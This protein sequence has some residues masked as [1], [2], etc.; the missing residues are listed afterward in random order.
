MSALH[1][2]VNLVS[3]IIFETA[4][5]CVQGGMVFSSS[6]FDCSGAS[7]DQESTPATTMPK[8]M[9]LRPLAIM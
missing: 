2:G 3:R 6:L 5:H 7:Q 8:S 9:D 4:A 1:C